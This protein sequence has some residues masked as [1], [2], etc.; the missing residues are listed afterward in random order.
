M[1]DKQIKFAFCLDWW[2]QSID[3]TGKFNS[4]KEALQKAVVVIKKDCE[5]LQKGNKVYIAEMIQGDLPRIDAFRLIDDLYDDI[6]VEYGESAENY[7]QNVKDK[8]IKILEDKLN[9]VLKDWIEKYNYTPTYYK[10]NNIK[11]YEYDG[12]DWNV[13]PSN[14]D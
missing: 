7:L 11:C 3:F 1:D 13:V 9:I 4:T 12:N 10:I 2:D 5:G 14:L 8:H 6:Y